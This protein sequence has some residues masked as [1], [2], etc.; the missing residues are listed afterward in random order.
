MLLNATD[1]A[2]LSRLLDEALA[3]PAADLDGWLTTLPPAQAHLRPRLRRLFSQ[4]T[5]RGGFLDAGPVLDTGDPSV[6]R[7]GDTVGPY[8]LLHELGHG[9]MG[10]VWLAERT[11]GGLKRRVALKLP[12]LAWGAGLAQRMARERDIGALLEHPHIA[13]LYDVGIDALGRPFL[14]FEHIDGL[15]LDRWCREQAPSMASRLQL[16]VQVTRAVAYAHARLVVHRDLKPSNVL[17]DAAGQAHLLDFGIAKLLDDRAGG[18]LTREQGR[19]FTPHYASP[20]QIEGGPITVATD[21]YSLG[22][23]LYELLTSRRPHEPRRHGAGA[24]EE[25]I[26]GTEPALASTRAATPADAKALR[27][28]VDAIVAKALRRDPAARYATADALADDIE[29]HLS[30]RPV[31]ARPDSW[32]DRIA[33]I[34]RRHRLSVSAAAALALTIV[35]GLASTLTL[36]FQVLQARSATE[37]QAAI[38]RNV[39]EYLVRDLLAAANPMSANLPATGSSAPLPGQVPVRALLDR[40]AD[41]AGKRFAGQPALEAAVRMSLGEAYRGNAAFRESTQQFLLAHDRF[42]AARPRQPLLEATALFRAGGALLDEDDFEAAGKWF[43]QALSVVMAQGGSNS[44]DVE[45]LRVQVRQA[46]GWLLSKK[47]RFGEAIEVMQD[48]VPALTQAFGAAS[49]EVATALHR[50]AISQMRHGRVSEAVSTARKAVDVGKQAMGS[51]HPKLVEAHST[52][53]EALATAGQH[54]EAEAQAR[55][56]YEM[57][58]QLLGADHLVTLIAEGGLGSVLHDMKRFDEAI[59]LLQDALDRCAKRYGELAYDTSVFANNLGVVY[60]DAG[61]SGDAIAMFERSQ[62]IKKKLF[63]EDHADVLI[64]EHNIA[65][66]LAGAGRWEEAL[67]MEQRVLPRAQK[68]WG[69]TAVNLG[70]M[71]RLL[72]RALMHH[73]RYAAARAALLEARKQYSTALGSEHEFV[74][75]VEQLLKD[76][77]AKEGKDARTARTQ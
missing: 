36:Y 61:R 17:V 38:A 52:L 64:I 24:V 57:S 30:G 39:N 66:E 58:R 20:E 12:R 37:G 76:V 69:P 46:Q 35:V 34:W 68:A 32:A 48:E 49:E 70:A 77:E 6:A 73:N 74:L 15:P 19:V 60:S 18:E 29:R 28:E 23:L 31:R 16:F 71:Y 75:Q 33:R 50:I 55:T 53:A 22:V 2:E 72:G 45:R 43:A 21:V 1:V 63:G 44:A 7:A 25:A 14:A 59:V 3:L 11:D 4:H 8:A 27:G 41:N 13:R 5:S 26:L 62:K 9:G 40:A 54:A 65:H 67:E 10:S 51:Q 42:A 47:G 56:A